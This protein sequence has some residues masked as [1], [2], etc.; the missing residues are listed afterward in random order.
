MDLTERDQALLELQLQMLKLL[1]PGSL[2]DPAAEAAVRENLDQMQKR[3]AAMW[4][5]S[6]SGENEPV[7]GFQPLPSR[8]EA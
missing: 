5:V 8:R 7:L 6:L 3:V 1:H 2:D 4:K